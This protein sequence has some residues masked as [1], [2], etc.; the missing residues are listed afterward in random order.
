MQETI[1][2]GQVQRY[3]RTGY[4]HQ[5]YRGKWFTAMTSEA[6]KHGI[7]W[8]RDEFDRYNALGV[9]IDIIAPSSGITWVRQQ[10]GFEHPFP[11]PRTGYMIPTVVYVPMLHGL[12]GIVMMTPE[13]VKDLVSQFTGVCGGCLAMMD[14]NEDS[15]HYSFRQLIDQLSDC[16]NVKRD[17]D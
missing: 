12:E 4:V 8:Y 9:A 16:G 11:D 14:T 10:Q 2:I 3:A 7:R 5:T 1:D 17:M 15:G 6:Y 13:N